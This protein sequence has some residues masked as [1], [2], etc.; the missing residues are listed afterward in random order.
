MTT[1]FDKLDWLMD[2]CPASFISDCTVLRELIAWVDEDAFSKFFNC[3]CSEWMI[4]HPFGEAE[5][6]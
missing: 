4:D 3:K 6:A 5:E 2:N 1:R